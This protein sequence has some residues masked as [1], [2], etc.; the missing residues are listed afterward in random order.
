MSDDHDLLVLLDQIRDELVDLAALAA[1]AFNAADSI[2]RNPRHAVA[3]IA[4][5]SDHARAAL[6][7]A[8]AAVASRRPA[9]QLS[10]RGG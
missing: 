6:E 5:V 2:P 1:A 7:R 3:L 9:A 10:A 8:D 4:M